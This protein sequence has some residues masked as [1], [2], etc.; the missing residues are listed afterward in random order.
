MMPQ[1]K[2]G[3]DV[4]LQ[5]DCC[6]IITRAVVP[7]LTVGRLVVGKK[8]APSTTVFAKTRLAKLMAKGTIITGKTR[9]YFPLGDRHAA[10][11]NT[12]CISPPPGVNYEDAETAFYDSAVESLWATLWVNYGPGFWTLQQAY[13]IFAGQTR[14]QKPHEQALQRF[15]ESC[16]RLRATNVFLDDRP[17]AESRGVQLDD[18]IQVGQS[19]CMIT[20]MGGK[21]AA[22]GLQIEGYELSAPPAVYRNAL[23][24]GQIATVPFSLMNIRKN[25]RPVAVT[26]PRILARYYLIG[27]IEAMRTGRVS[28]VILLESLLEAIGM[29]DTGPRQAYR[30]GQYVF[31]VLNYWVEQGFIGGFTARKKMKKINAWE[32]LPKAQATLTNREA[33]AVC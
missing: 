25:G 6:R 5:G 14:N 30:M 7:D 20:Y 1:P 33:A 13:R 15:K 28:S 4:V 3:I 22:R 18:Y 2:K 11:V 19:R 9:R 8:S 32:I 12:V 10:I 29:K 23:V 26:T 27:R 24:S 17:E 16:E 21:D 31:D